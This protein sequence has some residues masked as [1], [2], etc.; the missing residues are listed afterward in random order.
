MTIRCALLVIVCCT[1]FGC[2][3]NPAPPTSKTVSVPVG[4]KYR[5]FV[6]QSYKELVKSKLLSPGSAQFEKEPLITQSV[7]QGRTHLLAEGQVDAQNAFGG[8]LRASYFC[9]WT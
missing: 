1:L 3:A 8:L 4:P 2:A 6:L 5:E 7:E 9:H